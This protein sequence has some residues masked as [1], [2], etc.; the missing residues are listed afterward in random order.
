MK[1]PTFEFIFRNMKKGLFFL[2]ASISFLFSNS[3][4]DEVKWSYSVEWT[5][6]KEATLIFKAKVLENWHLY[7]QEYSLN[8]MA[9]QFATTEGYTKVGKVNEP[10][11]KRLYDEYLLA[12]M[13]YFEALNVKFTQK[14]Q[15]TA[16]KPIQIKGSIRGQVCTDEGICKPFE[17]PFT[18]Q[19]NPEDAKATTADDKDGDGVADAEDACP[20]EAGTVATKGCPDSDRDGITD[21][22][23]KC[24]ADSGKVEWGGCPDKDG[25]GVHDGIDRCPGVSG[26]SPDG[27]PADTDDK[28]DAGP[29]RNKPQQL[30]RE[31]V[32][33]LSADCGEGSI[34]ES[35]GSYWAIFIGGFIG[36]LLAL[37]M[38]CLFPMIPLTVSFFTKQSKTRAQGIRN[39]ILYGLSIIVIYTTIGFLV[40][41]A[42]GPNALNAMSTGIFWNLLFFAIF[43]VFAISFLGAFEI[44]LPSRFVNAMDKQSGRAGILGIFFMAFTLSLV[45]F[46]CTGPIIGA[47]LVEAFR[48]GS[49]IGPL[50]GMVGFSL[51]LALPFGLFAAF[52]G[53]LQ[54]LPRSGGWMEELKVT[55]GFLEIALALKFLSTIDLAYHWG[56]LKR[57]IFIGAWILIGFLWALWAFGFF[58]LFK[59]QKI[60]LGTFR[61][62]VGLIAIAATA[63]LIP[64]MA[65]ARLS[66]LSGLAPPMHYSLFNESGMTCPMGLDCYHDF[67]EGMEE[68]RKQNKPVLVDFT[69][70][71]CVNC[72]KME[73]NVWVADGIKEMITDDYVVI[74]LY[75][76]DKTEIPTDKQPTSLATGKKL[77]TI[78]DRWSDFQMYYFNKQSQPH[79]ILLDTEGKLL[80]GESE[81]TSKENFQL[82]LEQGLC[83]FGQRKNNPS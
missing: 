11:P 9:F 13:V 73:E 38:P 24:P 6:E 56:F 68:A 33:K 34:S 1:T 39:A 72:R 40:T 65:G 74:S 82:F 49:T 76:D 21:T 19:V 48:T 69:G 64:G 16:D 57:E 71:G 46:S 42:A 37:L 53:W 7:S 36:G 28:G 35:K 80:N 59:K 3:Q 5:G 15:L 78:G 43:I 29:T 61:I 22:E 51:A 45:S 55:L 30:T 18:F 54:S 41:I 58:K 31:N 4:I 32:D 8:P 17:V 77:T 66:L 50:A 47:L 62:I 83:R 12:D 44:T 27:C 81:Y 14:I 2:I 79:Y 10:K 60:K 67:D 20:D 63:Y 75:V 25:D 23:D 70:H 52:P 26:T